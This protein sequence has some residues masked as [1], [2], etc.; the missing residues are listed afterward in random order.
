MSQKLPIEVIE[1]ILVYT[2]LDEIELNNQEINVKYLRF[3]KTNNFNMVKNIPKEEIYNNLKNANI[4]LDREV[5]Y[6]NII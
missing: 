6:R 2:K 5:M 4:D 3:C 1:G